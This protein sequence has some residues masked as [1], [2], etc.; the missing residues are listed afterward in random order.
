MPASGPNPA[1]IGFP[2]GSARVHFIQ[3]SPQLNLG[4]TNADLYIDNKLAFT[5][6]FYAFAPPVP[7]ISGPLVIGPVTPYIELPIGQHDFR[8]V[9]HGTAFPTFLETVVTL[10]AN[11]KYAAIAQG[12]AG[13]SSTAFGLYVEPVYNTSN[14]GAAVSVFN[15]SPRTKNEAVACAPTCTMD[16]LANA[17]NINTD[18]L[19]GSGLTV[20]TPTGTVTGSWK[21]NVLLVPSPSY[22]I[23]AYTH[24]T[25][26]PLVGGFPT[27]ASDEHLDANCTATLAGG[28]NVNLYLIDL[29]VSPLTTSTILAV[30]DTNG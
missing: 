4:V 27:A 28:T 2:G 8:L 14:A 10:K 24:G 20:G 11:T 26:T 23:S 16:F 29:G 18:T 22:C 12:D 1:A 17:L 21:L 30:P 5:N 25:T 19:I 9:Q 6:F 7:A 15:A 13:D 3:G